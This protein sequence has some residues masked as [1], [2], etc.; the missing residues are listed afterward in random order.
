MKERVMRA[1]SNMAAVPQDSCWILKQCG[2]EQRARAPKSRTKSS[3]GFQSWEDRDPADCQSKAWVGSLQ[4][5]RWP[6]AVLGLIQEQFSP[7]SAESLTR[8]RWSVFYIIKK[9]AKSREMWL[10]IKRKS[11]ESKQTTNDSD[12]WVS[13][14]GLCNKC[15][16]LMREN[17]EKEKNTT[18]EE[19]MNFSRTRIYIFLKK[20]SN[21]HSRTDKRNIWN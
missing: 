13:R 21:R 4:G 7:G 20:E 16:K 3:T 5:T 11:R 19:R 14:P 12:I 18:Y 17:L 2:A 10:I 8:L 6:R 15:Y 9:H 1:A